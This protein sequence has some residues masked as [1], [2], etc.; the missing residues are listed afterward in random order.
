MLV[1]TST[2]GFMSA[3][4][5]GAKAMMT[6]LSFVSRLSKKPLQLNVI[7]TMLN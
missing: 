5:L 4:L 7:G 6:L 1:P 3:G 2:N